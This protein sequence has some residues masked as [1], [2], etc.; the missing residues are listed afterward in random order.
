MKRISS[1]VVNILFVLLIGIAL[2]F[3]LS[4]APIPHGP[5][6]FTV[7]SGSMEPAIH[8]GSIILVKPEETY[9]VGDIVTRALPGNAT[10]THRII[11]KTDENG[12]TIYKTK[13]DANE[14]EDNEEFSEKV[15]IGK[16]FFSLPY[17]GYISSYARTPIGFILLI[18]IPVGA[19]IALETRNI[20]KEFRKRKVAE[21]LKTS[22]ES[23]KNYKNE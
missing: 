8:A 2:L 19:I 9:L 20:L 23:S 18:L 21:S 13:G 3:A 16:V 10:V 14:D 15:I 17:F 7:M 1:I 11:E 6:L 5:K 12:K 22:K 4:L